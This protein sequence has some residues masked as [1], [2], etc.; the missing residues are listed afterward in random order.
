M[1]D[2][3]Q[4]IPHRTPIIDA[5]SAEKIDFNK[6][7][8]QWKLLTERIRRNIPKSQAV[9]D[10]L[11]PF[12]STP[13]S[14]SLPD[15]SIK[16][17]SKNDP[18]VAR[19]A[20]RL[21][22]N[23]G[24]FLSLPEIPLE[25][26][27]PT[28]K[29][30]PELIDLHTEIE[31][32]KKFY[33]LS[34]T[35]LDFESKILKYISKSG[36]ILGGLTPE[37]KQMA[38]R[39]YRFGGDIK[40][41]AL[42]AEIYDQKTPMAFNEKGEIQLKSG[43]QIKINQDV[44]KPE[45]SILKP[46]LWEKRNQLEDRV[47][48]IVV[49]GKKYIMKEKKTKY[50]KGVRKGGKF[51]FNSP[52]EEFEIGKNLSVS[53]GTREGDVRTFF[54]LPLASISFPDGYAFTVLKFEEGLIDSSS[55]QGALEKEILLKQIVYQEEFQKLKIKSSLFLADSRSLSFSG[56]DELTFD[57]FARVKAYAMKFEADTLLRKILQNKGLYNDDIKMGGQDLFRI[58]TDEKITLDIVCLDY[59]SMAKI[60]GDLNF[61]ELRLRHRKKEGLGFTRWDDETRVSKAEQAAYLAMYNEVVL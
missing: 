23:M 29:T 36:G 57:Q 53:N 6:I 15:K 25:L 49:D 54:E 47:Y 43:V 35:D 46:E 14:E 45:D 22:N 56:E 50:H 10:S 55:V 44:V 42:G 30:A 60:S 21:K 39:R 48:V 34:E 52:N 17:L 37:E 16:E 2:F 32:I 5:K 13:F 26:T 58:N 59:E 4:S 1:T 41:L 27:E 51:N 31:Q 7:E 3:E 38:Y 18:Q 40:I 24:E 61:Y 33:D 28:I 11:I 19:L 12:C 9:R 20:T 8:N